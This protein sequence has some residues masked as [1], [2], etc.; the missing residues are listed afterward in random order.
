ML[1]DLPLVVYYSLVHVMTPGHSKTL[2]LAGALSGRERRTMLSYAFGFSLAHGFLMALAVAAGFAFKGFLAHLAGNHPD[3]ILKTSLFVLALACCYFVYESWNIYSN[4]PR[5]RGPR[6]PPRMAG[7]APG[8]NRHVRRIGSLPRHDRHRARGSEH[9]GRAG[10]GGA[11]TDCRLA[12]G[13]WGDFWDGRRSHPSPHSSFGEEVSHPR[14]V[15][16]RGLR[17]HLHGG[18]CLEG[19]RSCLRNSSRSSLSRSS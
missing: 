8:L 14:M 9:G 11:H 13:Q 18:D 10:S 4:Q 6:T 19:L 2:L 17:R 1:A 12:H 3:V 5:G 15:S 7:E 16:I